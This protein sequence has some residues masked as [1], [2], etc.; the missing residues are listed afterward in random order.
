MGSD[1]ESGLRG[2]QCDGLRLRERFARRFAC[3]L[4][5]IERLQIY[6]RNRRQVGKVEN[7]GNSLFVKRLGRKFVWKM[8]AGERALGG[9]KLGPR[10]NWPS[11]SQDAQGFHKGKLGKERPGTLE[12]QSGPEVSG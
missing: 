10:G 8:G 7:P 5:R 3:A 9:S 4:K 6:S 2:W 12:V 11:C 1:R